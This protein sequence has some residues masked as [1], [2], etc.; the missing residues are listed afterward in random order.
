MWRRAVKVAAIAAS[1]PER[2]S[3]A[4]G[5]GTIWKNFEEF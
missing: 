5:R 4:G 1:H 2:I 3:S